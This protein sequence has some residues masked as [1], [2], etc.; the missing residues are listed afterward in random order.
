MNRDLFK[1]LVA[2]GRNEIYQ[3]AL[4]ISAARKRGEGEEKMGK[5]T[6][7]ERKGLSRMKA[8]YIIIA[9]T[10][11]RCDSSTRSPDNTIV[12]YPTI[13]EAK[14]EALDL[15]RKYGITFKVFRYVGEVA[16][17]EPVWAGGGFDED[18]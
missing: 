8:Y 11:I 18:L 4:A 14:A 17:G 12:Q 10:E 1:R 7:I 9:G 5:I 13:D 15:A 6:E 16:T 2:I 3:H